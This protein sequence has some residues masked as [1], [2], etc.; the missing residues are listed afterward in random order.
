[1]KVPGILR[2]T[3]R[4]FV[5]SFVCLFVCSF[6]CSFV[7]LLSQCFYNKTS[8]AALVQPLRRLLYFSVRTYNWL[9]EWSFKFFASVC[10]FLRTYIGAFLFQDLML[11]DMFLL[12]FGTYGTFAHTRILVPCAR[13]QSSNIRTTL[14]ISI[15]KEREFDSLPFYIDTM[16]LRLIELEY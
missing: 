15:W 11:F 6:V 12:Y 13:Y 14:L 7:C 9:I 4:S 8:L 16:Y 10:S 1:M 3:V 5:R 2:Y